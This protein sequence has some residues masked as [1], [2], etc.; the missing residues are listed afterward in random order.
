MSDA[1]HP[2]D[3]PHPGDGTTEPA[4]QPQPDSAEAPDVSPRMRQ[5]LGAVQQQN[6]FASLVQF[7]IV[8]LGIV[9]GFQITA[10]GNA[11]ADRAKEQGY[12]AQ[13]A[14]EAKATLLVLDAED[15]VDV[16]GRKATYQLVRSFYEINPPSGDTLML[17]LDEAIHVS[18]PQPPLGTAEALIATGDLRLIRH[19]DLRA[20]IALYVEE[21]RGLKAAHLDAENRWRDAAEALDRHIDQ[22][23]IFDA[24]INRAEDAAG[25]KIEITPDD[26]EWIVPPAPRRN[27]FPFDAN[28]FFANRA[29]FDA[30]YAMSYGRADM[31]Q[32]RDVMREATDDLLQHV[33]EAQQNWD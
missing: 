25:E 27:P 15:E 23:G 11:R 28:Q 16:D 8:V 4:V 1:P 12:L 10:W 13:L 5:V 20:T 18:T 2:E 21:M 9:I 32:L 33:L 22:A 29:A 26:W 7:V 19:D 14:D 31:E 3:P 17:L 30:L 6:W 24:L